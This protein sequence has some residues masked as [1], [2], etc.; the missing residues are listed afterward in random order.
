MAIVAKLGSIAILSLFFVPTLYTI[1]LSLYNGSSAP[2]PEYPKLGTDAANAQRDAAAADFQRQRDRCLAKYRLSGNVSIDNPIMDTEG[3]AVDRS[4]AVL[5]RLLQRCQH[6][7]CRAQCPS[8]FAPD[9]SP[10]DTLPFQLSYDDLLS[11]DPETA[12]LSGASVQ[13]SRAGHIL[14]GTTRRPEPKTGNHQII[15]GAAPLVQQPVRIF[16]TE[17]DRVPWSYKGFKAVYLDRSV[18]NNLISKCEACIADAVGHCRCSSGC[19]T[20]R[21]CNEWC[22]TSAALYTLP[23]TPYL[24]YA[25]RAAVT[26]NGQVYTRDAFLE[27]RGACNNMREPVPNTDPAVAVSRRLASVLV[28]DHIWIGLYEFIME[29]LSRLALF[30]PEVTQLPEMAIHVTSGVYLGHTVPAYVR[31]WMQFLGVAPQRIVLGEVFADQVLVPEI[32]CTRNQSAL[33]Q[34]N[35]RDV[36]HRQLGVPLTPPSSSAEPQAAAARNTKLITSHGVPL[37]PSADRRTVLVISRHRRCRVA[38]NDA[39]VEALGTLVR[40]LGLK[41]DVLMDDVLDS[42]TGAAATGEE[43]AELLRRFHRAAVVIAPHGPSLSYLVACREGTAVLEFLQPWVPNGDPTS[44]STLFKEVA[45][46]LGLRYYATVP[47]FQRQMTKVL[48]DDEQ[49]ETDDVFIVDVPILL[50]HVSRILAEIEQ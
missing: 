21:Q 8:L 4:I 16:R 10:I 3:A 26:R 7:A 48:S 33:F 50:D 14:P 11:L 41:V 44:M 25:E 19:T 37:F 9:G 17:A 38:N 22:S 45:H 1:M 49:P 40:P 35:L 5:V 28:I 31:G 36:V 12:S 24:L 39:M 46:N 20:R 42:V 32:P 34:R 6:G 15:G 43:Q 30:H 27:P 18:C 23:H 2:E 13:G 47:Q 29:G